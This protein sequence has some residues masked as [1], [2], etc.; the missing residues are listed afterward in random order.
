MLVI[1]TVVMCQLA[2]YERQNA[3]LL[4]K[5]NAAGEEKK[6]LE[7]SVCHLQLLVHKTRVQ[8]GMEYFYIMTIYIHYM[9]NIVF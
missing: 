4:E 3:V 7:R 9:Y 5:L 2:E 6:D 1:L 8:A